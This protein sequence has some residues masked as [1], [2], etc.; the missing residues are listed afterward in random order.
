MI[1]IESK[2]K[3]CQKTRYMLNK[4]NNNK[5]VDLFQDW[6]GGKESREGMRG[7]RGG[8]NEKRETRKVLE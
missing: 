1:D 8:K 2:S 3:V 4:N 6:L 5:D 7:E